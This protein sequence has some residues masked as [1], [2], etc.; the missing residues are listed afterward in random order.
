[1]LQSSS[2]SVYWK[3][4]NTGALEKLGVAC[5]SRISKLKLTSPKSLT[6]DNGHLVGHYP[7]LNVQLLTS[8]GFNYSTLQ[9][10]GGQCGSIGMFVIFQYNDFFR[11]LPRTIMKKVLKCSSGFH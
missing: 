9:I 10:T 2:P 4:C 6:S 8:F 11:I 1:M 7:S 3:D 5:E